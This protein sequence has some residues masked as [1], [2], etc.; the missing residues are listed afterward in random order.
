[1]WGIFNK[2]YYYQSGIKAEIDLSKPGGQR[3]K[4]IRVRLPD[5]FKENEYEKLV[6]NK[7]YTVLMNSYMWAGGDGFTFTK[8]GKFHAFGKYYVSCVEHY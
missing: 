7:T 6:L 5:K 3:V 8:T 1:M 2:Y 4:S